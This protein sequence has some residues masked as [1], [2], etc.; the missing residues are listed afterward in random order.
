M[1]EGWGIRKVGLGRAEGERDIV[2]RRGAE[3]GE[4]DIAIGWCGGIVC[5]GSR[6]TKRR[7]ARAEVK[8]KRGREEGVGER[9]RSGTHL[10]AGPSC[11]FVWFLR[12]P[13]RPRDPSRNM[14][15]RR[16]AQGQ[17]TFG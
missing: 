6:S 9:V 4:A 17:Q 3:G 8:K 13:D 14:G 2:L 15:S 12:A 16:V 10:L 1:C 11:C 7:C 5:W